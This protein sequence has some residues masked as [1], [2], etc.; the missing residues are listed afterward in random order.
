MASFLICLTQPWTTGVQSGAAS[1][2]FCP[3]EASGWM[4]TPRGNL[5]IESTISSAIVAMPIARSRAM[6]SGSE[7]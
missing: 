2:V 5:T 7:R 6:M 1:W 4:I 3:A